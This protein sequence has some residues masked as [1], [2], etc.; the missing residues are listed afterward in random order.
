M[1]NIKPDL[2]SI[3]IVNWNGSKYF[4]CL[5][6]SLSKI[7]TRY[8]IEIIFVDNASSDNSLSKLKKLN[9]RTFPITIVKNTEN[10]G[11]AE[12]NNTGIR[13]SQGSY[14][15]FLNND[16]IM[17]PDTVDI[18]MRKLVSHKKIGAV[19]PKIMQ[20]PHKELLD[21][22][23]SYFINTGFLYHYGYNKEDAKKYNDEA[24]VFSLK[25]AC[26][27]FKKS[28]LDTVGYFDERYFVYFEET[29][30]CLRTMIAGYDVAIVPQAVLFHEGGG[31]SGTVQPGFVLKHAYK[32]RIFTY[33]KNFEIMTLIKVLPFHIFLNFLAAFGYFATLRFKQ[34]LAIISAVFWNVIHLNQAFAERKKIAQIRKRSD[35]S[36]LPAITK[37]VKWSYYLHLFTSLKNYIDE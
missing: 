31:T 1:R 2:I 13:A 7:K 35:K 33:L 4:K 8:P 19:Q 27:L 9:F 22:V 30:L 29:D 37:K 21:S 12:G 20:Y 15:L 10:L 24:N 17:Q 5:F 34:G 36:Y 3:I 14:I 28:V 26:M 25:G 32:N 6:L 11:F 16:T 18:L 23:G